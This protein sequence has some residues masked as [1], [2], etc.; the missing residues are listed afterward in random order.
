MNIEVTA[1]EDHFLY[2]EDVADSFV[3][4]V[5]VEVGDL[6]DGLSGSLGLVGGS[7][8]AVKGDDLY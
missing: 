7:G 1:V 3:D 6:E 5:P 8:V 2:S 4:V